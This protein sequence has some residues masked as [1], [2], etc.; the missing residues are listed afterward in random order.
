MLAAVKK[1]G[2]V[3]FAESPVKSKEEGVSLSSGSSVGTEAEPASKSP[4]EDNVLL[5]EGSLLSNLVC[6]SCNIAYRH[7]QD[8]TSVSHLGKYTYKPFACL[9][10]LV[11]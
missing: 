10:G 11:A 9:D 5:K 3:K 6:T 4:S 2:K 1:K 7:C 8:F